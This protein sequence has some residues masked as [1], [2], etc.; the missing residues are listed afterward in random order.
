MFAIGVD[1]GGTKCAVCLGQMSED[2]VEILYK[3]TPH[4]T[5]SF[6]PEEMIHRLSE[7]VRDCMAHAPRPAGRNWHQLWRPI[8]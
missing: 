8:G 3:C 1:I 7:D 5:A 2:S 6:S 4:P